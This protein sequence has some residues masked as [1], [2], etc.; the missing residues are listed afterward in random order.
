MKMPKQDIEKIV[1]VS[2]YRQGSELIG[3]YTTQIGSAKYSGR[4]SFRDYTQIPDV[5]KH[6]AQMWEDQVRRLGLR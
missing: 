3:E 2:V 5:C 4:I 1:T 6:V